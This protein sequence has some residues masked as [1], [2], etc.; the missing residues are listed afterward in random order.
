MDGLCKLLGVQ[1][2]KGFWYTENPSRYILYSSI[3]WDP[4]NADISYAACTTHP[5]NMLWMQK[6]R[7]TNIR[8]AALFHFPF[9]ILTY[10][11]VSSVYHLAKWLIA[12][13]WSVGKNAHLRLTAM[14][15]LYCQLNKIN[16]L[17]DVVELENTLDTTFPSEILI[18]I[19]E[20][21]LRLSKGNIGRISAPW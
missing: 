6:C 21:I 20:V 17:R 4:Q 1:T 19:L 2:V 15:D 5:C 14:G 13:Y 3:K 18:K 12:P 16:N 9:Y 8:C 11:I 10:H 7:I